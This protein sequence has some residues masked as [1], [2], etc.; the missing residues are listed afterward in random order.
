M[1]ILAVD[2]GFGRCGVAV[3]EVPEC[4]APTD[5]FLFM[6]ITPLFCKTYPTKFSKI[7]SYNHRTRAVTGVLR[8]NCIVSITLYSAMRHRK[9]L[10]LANMQV[11]KGLRPKW[12][13]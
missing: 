7:F 1:T 5:Y 10:G 4:T 13:G 8:M 9:T 3:L 6:K 2:P 12:Q 11:S